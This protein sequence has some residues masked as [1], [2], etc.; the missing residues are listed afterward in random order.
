MKSK[1]G[2]PYQLLAPMILL[3]CATLICQYNST[4]S[5]L[6]IL[7]KTG[8]YSSVLN[9]QSLQILHSPRSSPVHA[10]LQLISVVFKSG[11]CEFDSLVRKHFDMD[12]RFVSLIKSPGTSRSP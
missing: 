11:G 10:L 4:E 2:N 5:S 9:A 3:L 7:N 12:V 1:G 8:E 6:I